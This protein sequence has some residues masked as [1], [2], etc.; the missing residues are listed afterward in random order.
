[1]LNQ[2]GAD[3]ARLRRLAQPAFAP[4]IVSSYL[5]EFQALAKELVSSFETVGRCEFMSEFAEPYAARVTCILIG[6]PQNQWRQLAGFA[7]EMGRA[8]AVTYMQNEEAV[9][10]ATRRM[11]E[12][13]HQLVEE[14]RQS[15]KD[16]FVG[17]LINANSDKDE[18][19]DQE[20][21]DL[22]VLSIFAGIE[23][24]RSQIGLAMHMFIEHPDQWRLLQWQ[25]EFAR[26]AVEE[27][28][29]TRPTITWMTR[30]AMDDFEFQGIDIAKGTTIH[31]FSE[32]A[33]TD[34]GHFGE[35]FDIAAR[36][37]P[38]FGF[39]GGKHHCIGSPIARCD[40]AEVFK[41]L[42]QKL[43]SPA[44]DGKPEFLPDS[45]NTSPI[46]LPIRFNGRRKD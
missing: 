5:P 10:A 37:K 4:R 36:R 6:L 11:F 31:L 22:I 21:H 28:M 26:Q 27:V 14:R 9:D 25:P 46:R 7:L 18:I 15:P 34:P 38:H 43:R 45:G 17:T 44:Y 35:G 19:G 24:T 8:L 1:M 32:S 29:R 13:S 20:L 12:F 16:D 30:E 41:L 2:E 33:A 39:G 3:H 42:A 40:M 23:T